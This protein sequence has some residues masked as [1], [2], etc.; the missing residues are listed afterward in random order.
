MQRNRND[1]NK[2]ILN[3]LCGSFGT[4]VCRGTLALL[5][6]EK[7]KKWEEKRM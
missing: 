3:G 1:H 4:A 7:K 2:F 6:N 5:V